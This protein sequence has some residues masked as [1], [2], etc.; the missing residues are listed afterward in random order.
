M[1]ITKNIAKV[2]SDNKQDVGKGIRRKP[3]KKY[4]D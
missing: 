3:T 4:L 1:T 2:V